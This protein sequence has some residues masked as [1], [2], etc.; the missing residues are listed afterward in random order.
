[1]ID[2]FERGKV[3]FIYSK[4]EREFIETTSYVA[5]ETDHKDV[6]SEKY[7]ELLIKIGSAVGSFFDFMVNSKSLDNEQTVENLRAKIL[8]EKERREQK[9]KKLNGL[10]P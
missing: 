10:R 4:L 8:K 9:Q 7:G 6:W 5:L 3:W 2:P 1:M